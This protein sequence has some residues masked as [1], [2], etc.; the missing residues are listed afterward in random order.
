[1][2]SGGLLQLHT[3]WQFTYRRSGKKAENTLKQKR[4]QIRRGNSTKYD[5]EQD[6][7][8]FAS[9]RYGLMTDALSERTTAIRLAGYPPDRQDLTLYNIVT[10]TACPIDTSTFRSGTFFV[11]ASYSFWRALIYLPHVFST[12]TQPVPAWKQA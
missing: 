7:G 3:P 5:C 10:N 8:L 12:W 6:K 11:L 4:R 1:M 2:V 9:L